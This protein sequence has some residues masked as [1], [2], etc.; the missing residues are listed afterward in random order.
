[1]TRA[2]SPRPRRGLRRQ[3]VT[4]VHAYNAFANI[5]AL[6]LTRL[7]GVPVFIAGEHGTVWRTSGTIFQLD[8]LAQRTAATVVANS[9]A[10]AALVRQRYGVAPASLQVVANAV[11]PLPAVDRDALR[12]SL[13]LEGAPIVGS[14]G[15]LDNPKDQ[16]TSL[17]A[18]ALALAQRDD[19]RFVLVGG[20]PLEAE[21]RARLHE[22]GLWRRFIMTGWRRDARGTDP[23]V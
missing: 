17:E 12:R 21:L 7:A 11:A 1:M 16:Q 15:R 10:A 3:R 20:G 14:V 19:L 4:V 8:R 23:G 22:L 2:A 6:A 18:A 13:G 5:W 9:E